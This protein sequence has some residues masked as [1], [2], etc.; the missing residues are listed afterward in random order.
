MI[1]IGTIEILAI[2]L[3]FFVFYFAGMSVGERKSRETVAWNLMK[4]GFLKYTVKDG[5][6][7]YVKVREEHGRN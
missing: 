7:Q 6:V 2:V 1:T 4:D 3:S 5:K